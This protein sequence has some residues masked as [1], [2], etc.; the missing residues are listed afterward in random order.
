MAEV[1]PKPRHGGSILMAAM[2]GIAD[3]LGW[4]QQEEIPAIV[5]DAPGEPPDLDLTFG[6]LDPL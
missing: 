2:I 6:P 3:A 1:L 4:D 5:A